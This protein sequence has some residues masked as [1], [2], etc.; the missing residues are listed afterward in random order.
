M[1]QLLRFE[2]E[3]KDGRFL[4]D[5]KHHETLAEKLE[6]LEKIGSKGA[7]L[8]FA[9]GHPEFL[10]ARVSLGFLLYRE[11]EF[12]NALSIAKGGMAVAEALIPE[13]FKGQIIW[14][15]L[16]NRPFLR[17]LSLAAL[18]NIRLGNHNEAIALIK[19]SLKYNPNDNVG[20]RGFLGCEQVRLGHYAYAK[21]TLAKHTYDFPESYYELALIHMTEWNWAEAATAL[22]QGFHANPYIAEIITGMPKPKMQTYWHGWSIREPEY[23][24]EYMGM[25][26]E[27]CRTL[28]VY[29][30]FVRWLF[31]HPAILVERANVLAC[32]E[33]LLW[34]HDIG[35]RGVISDRLKEL[36]EQQDPELS[37]RLVQHRVD[38]YGES[39]APWTVYE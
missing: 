1:E 25:Y 22:R 17:L 36:L 2:L 24:Q 16:D 15:W 11:D 20:L 19:R 39:V 7:L 26:G 18:S 34:T 14:G 23:A 38:R 37:E 4:F 35:Q 31:N 27:L 29:E 12:D 6:H 28:P 21:K 13:G 32:R 5:T 8:D 10:E 30:Q 33:E 9:G 3:D